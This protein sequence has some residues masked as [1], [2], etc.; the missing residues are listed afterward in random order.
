MSGQIKE[1]D[2][3]LYHDSNKDLQ[4]KL[5]PNIKSLYNE[6]INLIQFKNQQ[7]EM[8]I[9][10][11]NNLNNGIEKKDKHINNLEDQM[12]ILQDTE[13]NKR[14]IQRAKLQV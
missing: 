7:I 4:V 11:I 12:H 5:S 3:N 8:I 13:I 10:K 2:Y 6:L 1:Y 9:E 14:R